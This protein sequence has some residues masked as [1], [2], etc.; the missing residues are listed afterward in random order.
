M[1]EAPIP[2][3]KESQQGPSSCY[4]HTYTHTHIDTHTGWVRYN[5]FFKHKFISEMKEGNSSVVRN[6]EEMQKPKL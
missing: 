3:W 6:K 5:T 2:I 1:T 4:T